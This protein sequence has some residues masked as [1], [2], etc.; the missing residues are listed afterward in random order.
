MEV[1]LSMVSTTDYC[2]PTK[3]KVLTILAGIFDPLGIISP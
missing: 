1:P 3:R 2:S